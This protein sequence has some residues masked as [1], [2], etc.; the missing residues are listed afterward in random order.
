LYKYASNKEGEWNPLLDTC[1]NNQSFWNY[2]FTSTTKYMWDWL[3]SLFYNPDALNNN[4]R[5]AVPPT[6][7]KDDVRKL[8]EDYRDQDKAQRLL[9][10]L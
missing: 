7:T 9:E 10:K 3:H 6:I 5:L 1:K 4:F 8:L 2:Q